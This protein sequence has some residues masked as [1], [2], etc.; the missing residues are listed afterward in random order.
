MHGFQS[1]L[2][3]ILPFFRVI[4]AC[5]V[6]Y[7]AICYASV[8]V[9]ICFMLNAR[10]VCFNLY[11]S[12]LCKVLYLIDQRRLI[13]NARFLNANIWYL[14]ANCCFLMS[15]HALRNQNYICQF[16][17]IEF[18]I[19]F[20]FCYYSICKQLS[21]IQDACSSICQFLTDINFGCIKQHRYDVCCCQFT[22][23]FSLIFALFY[24]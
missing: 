24:R 18:S 22:G 6:L 13:L 20:N 23:F 12:I 11:L 7:L 16:V 4:C 17:R 21:Q 1:H 15:L 5:L 14:L 9:L 2:N 10:F 19:S 8:F 3:I